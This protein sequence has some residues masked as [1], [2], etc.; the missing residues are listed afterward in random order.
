MAWRSIGTRYGPCSLR[1]L[2]IGQ[3]AAVALLFLQGWRVSEVLGLAG[4]N[5]DH[6]TGIAH[7]HRASVYV[8]GRGQQLGPPKTEGAPFLDLVR[9]PLLE[10]RGDGGLCCARASRR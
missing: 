3:G 10:H 2:T 6:D 9:T 5:L 1:S 8:D 4:A 7:V